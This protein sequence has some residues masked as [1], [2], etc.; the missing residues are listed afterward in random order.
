[1]DEL[2]MRTHLYSLPGAICTVKHPQHE[3]MRSEVYYLEIDLGDEIYILIIREPK[4]ALQ[5]LSTNQGATFLESLSDPRVHST[6]S[7]MANVLEE[8]IAIN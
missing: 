1:M 4:M 5:N 3:E 8:S 7:K 2:E 6:Y